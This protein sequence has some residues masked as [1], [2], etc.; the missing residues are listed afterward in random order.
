MIVVDFETEA[1]VSGSGRMPKPVGVSIGPLDRPEDHRYYAFGHP[2]KNNC[3][4]YEAKQALADIWDQDLIFHHGKFDIGVAIEH[5][6]F[7][8]PKTW[9]DTM[10]LIYL[11]DPLADT[12]SLKP[13]AERIL[14]LPPDEQDAVRDWLISHGVVPSSSKN[15]GAHIC[16]APGDIVGTYAIGDTTRTGALF[17]HLYDT[18]VQRQMLPAYEREIAL[19]PILY[20]AE[21]KGVRIDR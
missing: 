4:E 21:Y 1:I 17:N 5:W 11:Y 2:T 12:V 7:E 10:Y 6:G 16:K 19:A 13:S 20:E 14:G 8:W 9:H 3:T 18:I 15:W